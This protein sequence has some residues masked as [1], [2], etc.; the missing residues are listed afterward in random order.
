[1][2]ARDGQVC[3][4]R[5]APFDILPDQ[6]MFYDVVDGSTTRRSSVLS[7]IAD[8]GGEARLPDAISL[9]EFTQWVAFVESDSHGSGDG[10]SLLRLCTVVKVT[11]MSAIAAGQ[12]RPG[13]TPCARIVP[14]L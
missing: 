11:P 5:S 4:T 3:L 8:A 14:S 2:L 7:N 12:G 6:L 13:D 10:L 1:M 9:S